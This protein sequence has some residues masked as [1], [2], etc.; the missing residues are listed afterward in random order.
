MEEMANL[1]KKYLQFRET[2]TSVFGSANIVL[3]GA[4]ELPSDDEV[5]KAGSYFDEH[6]GGN[7]GDDSGSGGSVPVHQEVH[8]SEVHSSHACEDGGDRA[9]GDAEEGCRP[10]PGDPALMVS[11]VG[12]QTVTE[13]RTF[14][15]WVCSLLKAGEVAGSSTVEDLLEKISLA[16]GLHDQ[17]DPCEHRHCG[18][19]WG[20]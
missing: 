18:V 12:D 19:A 5:S 10:A 9:P 16:C 1:S 11:L 7:P 15:C 6:H 8:S 3:H 13:K 17:N 20:I 14:P 2:R 4:A